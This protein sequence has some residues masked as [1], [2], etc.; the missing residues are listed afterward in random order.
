MNAI[1]TKCKTPID[2][3]TVYPHLTE[4]YLKKDV[5]ISQVPLEII[6][7]LPKPHLHVYHECPKCRYKIV[8]YEITLLADDEVD[9]LL[10]KGQ[11][12]S[13]KRTILYWQNWL[14]NKEK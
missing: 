7:E 11:V 2:Q 8:L 14:K 13:E 3:I 5:V 12:V 4:N 6:E 1:C 9:R 10:N